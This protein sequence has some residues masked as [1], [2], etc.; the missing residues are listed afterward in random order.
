[1]H[2]GQSYFWEVMAV[3][4]GKQVVAPVAPAPRAQFRILEVDKLNALKSLKR[5]KPISHLALGL[6]YARFGL[7]ND[8]EGEFQYF[9]KENPDS[10]TARRLLRTVQTWR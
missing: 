10:A 1:M 8:A 2:R 6:T 3:K 7:V 4:E 9:L 5:Q